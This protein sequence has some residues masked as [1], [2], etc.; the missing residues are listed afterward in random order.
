MS[1]PGKPS[2]M[3]ATALLGSVGPLTSQA[4][5]PTTAGAS[6]PLPTP[7]FGGTIGETY[8][9][10]KSDFP[11]PVTP[12]KDA[13]N[14]LVIL[15]DD[16][17]F[18][19]T[20]AYG[21]LT[22]TP[23]FDRLAEQG[24]R[25]N[26]MHNT[27]LCSPTRAALLSGRNH[28]QVGMG[29]ITEG[30]TGFPGYNSVWEDNNAAIGQVL[31]DH[32]YT[33]AAFGKWHDT[34]D[35]ETSAA[36]PFDRWPTGKGF[37]YFYGF[38][39]GETSQFY[40]Q[41]FENTVP[42]E[43]SK[44]PEQGY[45]FNEDLADHAIN[46]LREQ[47]SVAPKKPW[48]VYYAP[49]AMHAPHQVPASYIEPFKGKFDMG[50]DSYREMVFAQ[51]KKLGIVPASAKLT[52]R[53]AELPAWETLSDDQKRL[54][55]R[56]MEV[57]AGFLTQTDEQVGR[58]LDAAAKSPNADNTLVLLALGDNGASA[59]GG[60]NGTVNN[61]ATQNGIPDDVPNMLKVIDELGSPKHENHFSVGWAWAVDTPFQWT[62][63]VASH[64]GGTRSGFTVSW[65]ARIK[66]HGEVRNQWHHVID[67]AP[68]IYEAAGIKMPETFNGQKQVPLPGVSMLYSFNDAKAPTRHTTQYFEIMGN[69]A[70]YHDG[71]VAAARH[72]LPWELLGRKGDFENDKWELYDLS[73]DF[74][75][76]DD[77][78]AKNPAKLKQL[79]ALF[80]SEAKKYNVLPLDDRFVERGNVPDRPSLS[81]GREQFTFYPGTVRV[82]E[83][84]A[85]NV[86]ARS[87][88]VEAVFEVD[89][90][91]EGV[92]VAQGGS[93]GYT[94][95]V[96]D[97]HLVYE[98]NFFGKERD[99]IKSP[100]KLPAGKVVA[101]FQYT[102]EDKTFG[103]GG[104][105]VLLVNGKEVAR[106][107]FAHVPPIRYSATESF[108]I[109]RDTGEAV[110]TD[111]EGPFPFTGS[112]EKVDIT[113]Q[114]QQL[115]PAAQQKTKK[116][117]RDA[118]LATQ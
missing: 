84:T 30:A 113:I 45:S 83:G 101:E 80:E 49:G 42:V 43:P 5:S 79:Q 40:P 93:A 87:H 116:L 65:P 70:I 104:T 51:Q 4:A 89:A 112:L 39:G 25:Y 86:K 61:M 63:Q 33:T 60:L 72:G 21:G 117:E 66:A 106:A 23:N 35:W 115:S 95:F 69:R 94:L 18:A 90:K 47:Q 28:H 68:T 52:P 76:A 12:A 31:K 100:E 56:Q 16:L 36:G 24:L 62:K 6:L 17:G 53:P 108:D 37:G 107:R 110:S 27:A 2:V 81:R 78:A 105:G 10:S 8:K 88:T 14:V 46:W 73:K 96:K 77:L 3:L 29:G 34:P 20:S 48:F 92:I 22:P 98:N 109:G 38:Q 64:F 103:G 55:S 71:W 82:P 118:A 75:Q 111:Y 1:R 74:S 7:P 59:E 85:P 54:Y 97:G 13:P 102:H 26:E 41:L 91:T 19:G 15:I 44:T 67:V 32:G 11:Q 57:F 99:Q 58:V 114:P 9:T 50:W